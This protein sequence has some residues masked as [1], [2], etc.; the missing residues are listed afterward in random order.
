MQPFLT[1]L[2]LIADKA[3]IDSEASTPVAHTGTA[4]KIVRISN[5]DDAVFAAIPIVA[6]VFI[7]LYLIIKAIMAPFT[8]RANGRRG[9]QPAAMPPGG[10][11]SD[12]EHAILTKLHTT[13]TQ[14]ESR[15]ESLETILIEQPRTK[16]KYGTKL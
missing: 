1:N 3:D 5:S 13:I 11:L 2:V 4:H 14:M 9:F 16:E 6:I 8:Q 7:F 15:V 10:G 12:E